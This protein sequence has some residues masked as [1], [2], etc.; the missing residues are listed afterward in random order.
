[1]K[2]TKIQRAIALE[3]LASKNYSK[4]YI[5]D[6]YANYCVAL[7][8][9]GMNV[10]FWSERGALRGVHRELEKLVQLYKSRGDMP[11]DD[12]L[13]LEVLTPASEKRLS[14]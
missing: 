4:K 10:P 11:E 1:M 2:Q 5:L 6:A 3:C 9:D 13:G 12:F 7:K 14:Q 8:T